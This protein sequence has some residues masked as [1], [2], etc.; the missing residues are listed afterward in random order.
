MQTTNP[1]GVSIQSLTLSHVLSGI[2]F[3]RETSKQ[4][5][6]NAPVL[7]GWD[8][9]ELYFHFDDNGNGKLNGKGMLVKKDSN[10]SP[11]LLEGTIRWPWVQF[12]KVE[13]SSVSSIQKFFLK[14]DMS[15]LV[16]EGDH[17]NGSL[18]LTRKISIDTSHLHLPISVP[19]VSQS[20]AM[21][22]PM[23]TSSFNTLTSPSAQLLFAQQ[24]QQAQKLGSSLQTQALSSTSSNSGTL[25]NANLNT[26]SSNAT[27]LM[28]SF[29]SINS[30][31]MDSSSSLA[32]SNNLV[33]STTVSSSPLSYSALS[34][35]TTFPNIIPSSFSSSSFSGV[36]MSSSSSPSTSVTSASSQ[37][38]PSSQASTATTS[39]STLAPPSKSFNSIKEFMHSLFPSDQAEKYTLLLEKNEVDM[40]VLKIMTE[41]HLKEMGVSLGPRIK[42]TE[43]AKSLQ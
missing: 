25:N 9:C 2:W 36:S 39:S 33:L 16:M 7:I 35:A 6:S 30:I 19:M 28:D 21:R 26:L 3:G 18:I 42:I 37:E 41:T 20:N 13:I 8:N 12:L 14:I 40:D 43:A 17:A 15:R 24:S 27:M 5:S 4:L 11:F 10:P 32:S 34:A 38:S 1:M 22:L 31:L 29:G 23:Q